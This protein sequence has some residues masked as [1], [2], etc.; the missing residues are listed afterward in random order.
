LQKWEQRAYIRIGATRR[1]W[2]L[3]RLFESS[4]TSCMW[5]LRR[6]FKKWRN[7]LPVDF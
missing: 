5:T 6:L 1:L 4:A 7:T 3:R 2:T